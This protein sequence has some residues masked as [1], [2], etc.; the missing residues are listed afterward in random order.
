MFKHNKNTE[1]NSCE[2]NTANTADAANTIDATA[3]SLR[4]V[5]QGVEDRNRGIQS[6][7]DRINTLGATPER[8]GF[9]AFPGCGAA[10]GTAYVSLE[11]RVLRELQV[12]RNILE[13]RATLNV[14]GI[15]LILSGSKCPEGVENCKECPF[16]DKT[17]VDGCLES[18]AYATKIAAN[19][20]K[21]L[22]F[23]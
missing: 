15:S 19:A 2:S 3:G 8:M 13:D 14:A 5:L 4:S 10:E 20:S 18:M 9:V 12:I 7:L 22:Q 6:Y 1:S 16:Y 21:L 17:S 23:R 11:E